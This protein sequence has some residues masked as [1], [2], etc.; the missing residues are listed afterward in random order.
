MF[1]FKAAVVGAGTMG[2]QIAQTIAAAGIP[3]VLKDIDEE[4]VQAGLEE[5]RKVTAGQVGKLVERGKLSTEQ[6]EAQI[7]EIVGHIEGTTSYGGFGEVDFVIEAVPERMEIKQA[8]FA[9]LD[10]ATPGHAILASNTSSLSI[11]EIGEATLRPE[12]VVGFHYFYPAAVMPLIEVVEGDET[13]AETVTAA[14]TFAQTIRKQPIACAEVPGFVVNRILNSGIS[15]VWRAQEQQG[16]SIK[17]IDEGVGSANVVPMAPYLMLSLLGLDTVLHV[18]EHLQEAYG[19]ERFYVPKGMQKLVAEGKLGAKTG[20]DG[21]YTPE[22]APNL[23]GEGEPDVQALVELLT[24]KTFVE[25]CLVLEEGVAV[26]RDIDF[27]LMAGAGLD[28]RRGLMPPF[29]KAD[30]EGLD[31]ILERLENLQELHGERFAPPTILRRMVAQGRLGQKSGQGFYAYP[32]PDAQQ[33]GEGIVKLETRP[34][35]VAIA[36]LANGQMNSIAPQVIEDLAKVWEQVKQGTSSH[37]PVRA[38][39]IASS[40]PFLYSAGADIK[41]FTTLDEAGGEALVHK[42][43]ALFRELGSEGV[44][45]IAAVNGLAFGGGCELAMACDVRIAARSALFGQ[46]EIKLGIIPGFGGTQRLA[47]LV[48]QS[49]ALEMNLIG[50]PI[51]AEEAYE[52]GL[53]SAVV[54]DHELLDTALAWARRLAGQAPLAVEQIKRVSAKGD[55]DEGIEAEKRGFAT[56]FQSADGKEGIAAFLGKRAPRF[57]GK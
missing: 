56:V 1:V 18:A 33:P 27:G 15:E 39:V 28:P 25:A 44:A 52:Y 23:E 48:G 43:H 21:F 51:M 12:K 7:A 19:P 3:V 31:T 54:E 32:Q 10:A 46:P 17:L 5:A 38:L 55:L 53:A 35:G 34:E 11:T 14:V 47:R 4:L 45:T 9:E 8:V 57:T 50:D 30:A 42:A 20:G 41:A 22:G 6:G 29:M 40:N 36:W 26:H 13:S 37:P 16:L 24:L 2:G 49:K